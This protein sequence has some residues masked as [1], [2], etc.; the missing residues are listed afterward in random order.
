MEGLE[1]GRKIGEETELEGLVG[2]HARWWVMMDQGGRM[3]VRVG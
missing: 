3:V 2:F 1:N